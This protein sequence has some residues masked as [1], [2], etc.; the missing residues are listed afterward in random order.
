MSAGAR[1]GGVPARSPG[2]ADHAAG[3][4]ADHAAAGAAGGA[5]PSGPDAERAMTFVLALGRAA[6]ESGA[7]AHR[8]EELMRLVAPRVGLG[9]HFLS[10]PTSLTAAFGEPPH[11]RTFLAR[12]EPGSVHLGR[13]SALD[14]LIR[15]VAAGRVGAAEGLERVERIRTAPEPYGAGLTTLCFGVA[16]AG[17]ARF[18]GGGWREMAAAAAIGLA[19]AGLARLAGRLPALERM[20]EP[21]AALLAALVSGAAAAWLGHVSPYVASVAGIIVLVPGLGLTTALTELATR[22]LVSGTAR[23]A[24]VTLTFLALAGGLALGAALAARLW[25]VEANPAP[26]PLPGW[27]VWAA[28]AVTPP[29][30]AV[31]FR[32]PARDTPWVFAAGV[33]AFAAARLGTQAF[34]NEIGTFLAAATLGVATNLYARALDRP[35]AVPLVPG[36]LLLIPGSVGIRSISSLIER[37]VVAGVGLAFTLVLVAVSLA[38][39]VLFA[40]VAVSPRRGL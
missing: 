31:L 33:L 30:L 36:I 26:V 37:D 14:D 2:G 25:G 18:F 10:T 38:A 28:L 39:G 15:D 21:A 9:G 32:A 17:A 22:N 20:F 4:A 8:L 19:T 40:N 35:S 24:G 34:G 12:V 11:Q 6:H 1:R 7:P 16:S 23:L 29:A 5:A 27:T 3:G 13:Q